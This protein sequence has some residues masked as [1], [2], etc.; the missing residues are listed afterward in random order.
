MSQ[1]AHRN[2]MQTEIIIAGFGGQGVLFGGMLLAQA[3]V[4]ANLK[5]TWFPSYGA[6]M[7]GGTANSTVIVSDQEIGLPIVHHPGVLI[8]MNEL[9]LQKFLPRVK[10]GALVIANSSLIK[11]PIEF[12]DTKVVRL[13]ASELADQELG[14]V[15]TTNL[16]MIG[17]YLKASGLLPLAT[18][19]A[20]CAAAFA[21]RQKLI[22]LNQKAL[23]TGFTFIP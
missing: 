14:D 19:Q 15:R 12:E 9:S 5:T 17:A 22:P 21:D 10:P 1:K 4:E 3:A 16:V 8:A 23:A 20:A 2:T 6:E 18:A 7:R 13:P 11:G